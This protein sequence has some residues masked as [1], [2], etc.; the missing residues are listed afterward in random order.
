MK[1]SRLVSTIILATTFA[2]IFLFVCVFWF[3][4]SADSKTLGL[5]KDSL[6]T[7]SGF[8][9]GITTLIAAYIASRLFNDWKEQHNKQVLAFEAKQLH[10][11]L[12]RFMRS[13]AEFEVT[14]NIINPYYFDS[15][16]IR[17]QFQNL[18]NAHQ[19]LAITLLDFMDLSK[20]YKIKE[21]IAYK[22]DLLANQKLILDQLRKG[23]EKELTSSIEE[24]C[25]ILRCN[26]NAL[27]EILQ[28]YIFVK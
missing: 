23:K 9:G 15:T 27:K 4:S 22:T 26:T 21:L 8:F 7:T 18:D 20:Q 10:L 5:L 19:K 1:F 11:D 28:S 14:K 16:P 3:Y 12:S 6:S 17:H 13:I 25:Y 24:T 2:C